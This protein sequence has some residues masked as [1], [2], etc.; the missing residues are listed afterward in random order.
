[1]GAWN[2]RANEIYLQAMELGSPQQ[3]QAFLNEA[4]GDDAA[5]R[6][7]VESLIEAGDRAGEFLESPAAGAEPDIA[8]ELLATLERQD[9]HQPPLER[10]GAV[11][12]RYKLIE[13]IGEGGM[14]VVFK[15]EQT[16]PVQRTVALKVIRP[17]MDS[18][19]VIARFEAER[20]ALAVMD[21]PNIAKVLDAGT[22]DSGRPYF[23][24]ELVQGVP[25]TDYCDTHRLTPRHRLEL[26]IHVCRAVQ[27][28][29]TKGIIHRDLKPTNV[30]VTLHDG[31]PVPKVIDFGVAKAT[32]QQPLGGR[33]LFTQLTQLIGTPV[34][35]SP[36]QAEMSGLDVDTR[37][38]V[39][40][41]GVLL[42]ELLTGSTPFDKDRLR[43]AAQDEVRR[44]IREEDPPRPSTRLSLMGEKL[45]TVCANC[46]T[47]SKRL[48]QLVRGDLDW[49]VLKCLEKERA[50]RYESASALAADVLHLLADEPVSAGPPSRINQVRR[51]V[52]RN[53]RLVLTLT[54]L[55]I[56]LIAGI[57]GTTVG[58]V[59]QSRQRVRAELREQ[60]A[61]TQAAIAKTVNEFH[62]DM[63]ASADPARLLGDKVTV[64]QAV[65]AAVAALDAG[66]LKDEP[67]VEAGV[68]LTI[69]RTLYSLGRYDLAESNLRKSLQLRRQLLPAVNL[70]VAESVDSMAGVLHMQGR[71]AEA[72]PLHREVLDIR[73]KLLPANDPLIAR[74]LIGVAW[75]LRD[76]SKRAEAEQFSREALSILRQALPPMDPDLAPVVAR[77]AEVLYSEGKLA[78]AEP[79]SR[80]A[81]EIRRKALPAGHPMLALDL[82]QLAEVLW[83]RGNLA[84]S[85]PLY[86][87]A[88]DIRRKT[89]PVGHPEIARSLGYVG[90]LLYDEGR[91]VEAEAMFREATEIR[92]KALPPGH[93][94]IAAALHMVGL[95]LHGQ[96]RLDEAEQVHRE[97]LAIFQ[98]SLPLSADL[99]NV[100]H[101]LASVLQ[102]QGRIAEAES[103]FRDALDLARKTRAVKKEHEL[104]GQSLDSLGAIL[105]QQGKSAEAEPL[106]A[107]LYQWAERT[108]Y[109]PAMAARYM[110]RYGPCLLELHRYEQAEKPL[111]EAHRR[112][113]QTAQENNP[114]MQ[115]T[116]AALAEL[117]DHTNRAAEAARWRAEL[118]TL[119][120]TTQPDPHVRP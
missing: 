95:A 25:I 38:D 76:Q 51:F 97:A 78:E 79:F 34:Y 28:A 43:R 117:C 74:A 87:E 55:L 32:S 21:H 8:P 73:R 19:Q 22:T 18:Q 47:D 65:T 27:H 82:E 101:S 48:G 71:F 2:P 103:M 45:T 11:I 33:T 69:G 72:E 104:L 116:V 59:G 26:F 1:M 3:R 39:Y 36:E 15:A 90:W 99:P 40:S 4:C 58:L 113:Q 46:G 107:E 35:M 102:D 20:Q 7:E 68:R 30:L 9:A 49:I 5:L 110:A 53:K 70:D 112:L 118:A 42:Y 41:L 75:V 94:N 6:A 109:S 66:K 60:E 12:G 119:H 86:Y 93:P 10:P 16:N 100:M 17:G 92:R 23:V 108:Q 63:L 96:G 98:K 24:M 37:S 111:L 115:Q 54:A 67:L 31:A 80:E 89:L 61:I 13:Q 105:C 120:P 106:F 91:Y 52:R 81:L 50:R 88:L 85:T 14:G 56:V 29:H 64:L 83:S 57:I 44:I 62:S 84:E 114:L 77:L